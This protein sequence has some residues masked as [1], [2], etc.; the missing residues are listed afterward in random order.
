MADMTT[1]P[2]ERPV[3]DNLSALYADIEHTRA[4]LEDTVDE[5]GH[6]LDVRQRLRGAMQD[7]QDR[8][9]TIGRGRA[10][11][12]AGGGVA[13]VALAGSCVRARRRKER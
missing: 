13:V 11:A 9:G 8:I 3:P 1:R 5:I 12:I 7:A 10:A 2:D 6:R 4:S